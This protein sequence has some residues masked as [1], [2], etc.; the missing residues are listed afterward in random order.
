MA[1]KGKFIG[2]ALNTPGSSRIGSII[3]GVRGDRLKVGCDT[4]EVASATVSDWKEYIAGRKEWSVESDYLIMQWLEPDLLR[5][6]EKYMITVFDI[7]TP[8]DTY[9]TGT[10]ICT[11]AVHN[12]QTG[13]LAKGSYV[14]KG[15]GPL[16]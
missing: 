14:F 7:N 9:Y 16:R 4:I 8:D 13:S 15:T 6:G 5:V 12:Y 11:E 10:A 3:A 1:L 2:I